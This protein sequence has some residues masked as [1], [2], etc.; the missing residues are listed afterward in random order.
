MNMI[1]RSQRL[2]NVRYDIRGPVVQKA[3][4]MS[5]SGYDIIN[6]NI[7]NPAAFG[8]SAPDYTINDLTYN[9]ENSLPYS[10]SKGVS[11]AR[12][13]LAQYYIDKGYKNVS[14]DDI[15]L[16]NGVSELILMC[17][18]G[19]IN[20]GDEI[21][22]PAPDYPLWTASVNLSGGKAVHY[23]CDE[24]SDWNPDLLDIRRKITSKTKAIVLI[25]PNNPTGAVY[26]RDLLIEIVKIAREND[27]IIF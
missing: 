1:S 11:S 6:L 5:K 17:M 14:E 2:S 23:I 16:G 27:L 7:G 21:L 25:N 10:H 9:L 4:E 22:I 3:N 12:E 26:T 19:L 15:F 18:Q 24:Q 13:A 20:P 8:F